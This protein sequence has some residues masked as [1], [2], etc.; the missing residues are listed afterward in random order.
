MGPRAALEAGQTSAALGRRAQLPERVSENA[1]DH[2]AKWSVES[3]SAGETGGALEG[4]PEL[5]TIAER[6]A[7]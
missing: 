6:F 5:G 3:N 4:R 7:R 2:L 1:S